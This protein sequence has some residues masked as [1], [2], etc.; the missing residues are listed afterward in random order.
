LWVLDILLHFS[1]I[2]NENDTVTVTPK[3][4]GSFKCDIVFYVLFFSGEA[5][6]YINGNLIATPTTLHHVS[7]TDVS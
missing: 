1:E 4:D 3:G 6:T 7:I 5:Q 2:L